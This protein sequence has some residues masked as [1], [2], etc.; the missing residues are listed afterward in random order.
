MYVEASCAYNYAFFE[1]DTNHQR[2]QNQSIMLEH[3][4]YTRCDPPDPCNSS[5]VS[6]GVQTDDIEVPALLHVFSKLPVDTQLQVLSILFS[7]YLSA[8]SSVSVPDNFLCRAAAAMIHLHHGGCTNVLYNLDKGVGTLRQDSSD[9][10]FPIK[11]IPMSLIEYATQFFAADN[12][13]QVNISSIL[14]YRIIIFMQISCPADYVM[15]TDH[16]LPL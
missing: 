5:N 15:A 16:V 12:L 3:Q 10:Q 7:S 1:T 9:T 2:M 8:T 6:F 4:I 14:C 11:C 13:Q